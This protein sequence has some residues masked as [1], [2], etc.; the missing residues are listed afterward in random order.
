MTAK[1]LRELRKKE[2][3]NQWDMAIYLGVSQAS[4]AI[5]EKGY[6]EIPQDYH[7]KLSELLGGK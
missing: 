3:M 5:W 6:R 7:N 1:Q 4:I 2:G